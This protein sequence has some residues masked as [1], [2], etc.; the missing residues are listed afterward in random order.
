[1][2]LYSRSARR[3][4][5]SASTPSLARLRESVLCERSWPWDDRV[6]D[7][8]L[9]GPP[10]RLDAKIQTFYHFPAGEPSGIE[11]PVAGQGARP[12]KRGSGMEVVE[13]GTTAVRQ[14]RPVRQ[15][16]IDVKLLVVLCLLAV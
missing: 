2:P 12:R 16:W 6:L 9:G 11:E 3:G 1:M 13:D 4:R 15:V 8:L 14:A 7:F 5:L 10:A